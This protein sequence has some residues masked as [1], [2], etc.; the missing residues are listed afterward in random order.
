MRSAVVSSTSNGSRPSAS[1]NIRAE[2]SWNVSR[3]RA[4]LLEQ[5]EIARPRADVAA[6]RASEDTG[7]LRHVRHVVRDP[8]GEQLLER[9]GPE[10]RM[11]AGQREVGR[12]EAK[13]LEL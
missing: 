10:F 12:V 9:D 1:D 13:R 7:N 5:A 3:M 2:Y 4:P 8:A 6:E 11:N